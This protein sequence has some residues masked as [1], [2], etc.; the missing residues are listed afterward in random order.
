MRGALEKTDRR[1]IFRDGGKNDMTRLSM[2]SSLPV[3][4]LSVLGAGTAS[5]KE[6]KSARTVI[7]S[8]GTYRIAPGGEIRIVGASEI[9]IE[10][11]TIE[12][13]AARA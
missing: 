2:L 4:A 9:R 7:F 12:P 8:P 6:I 10:G 13:E 5:P 1:R 3:A 11:C